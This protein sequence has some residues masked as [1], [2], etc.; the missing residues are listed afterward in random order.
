MSLTPRAI[1][2]KRGQMC[3]TTGACA[4][5]DPW[6]CP[7][8]PAGLPRCARPCVRTVVEFL[9]P[10]GHGSPLH[11][12]YREDEWFYVIEGALTFWVGGQTIEAILGSF[13]YGPRGIPHTYQVGLA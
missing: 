1:S 3:A 5:V 8:K 13:V 2:F 4:S 11:V 7:R 12:H 6:A 10:Q 9:A